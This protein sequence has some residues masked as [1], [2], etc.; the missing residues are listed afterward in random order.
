[1][2][3]VDYYPSDVPH[4][5][6][7]W[8]VGSVD[9]F[10]LYF[11]FAISLIFFFY[12]FYKHVRAWFL[13]KRASVKPVLFSF[14]K[15]AILQVKL[16]K[17]KPSMGLSHIAIFWGMVILT[18]TTILVGIE[19]DLGIRFIH[20]NFYLVLSFVAELGG[21]FL[22]LGILYAMYRRISI[23]PR[24]LR[25]ITEDKALLILLLVLAVQGFIIEALR[26]AYFRY[27]WEHV[28]FVGNFLAGTLFSNLDEESLKFWHRLLWNIHAWTTMVFIG[29]I[30]YSKLMHIFTSPLNVLI[31][32]RREHT[33]Q[34][35]VH[36]NLMELM[37]REDVSE[38]EML[39]GYYKLED[40]PWNRILMTDACTVCGR[41][42][43]VCPAYLTF[44]PL[45]PKEV[46]L[47]IRDHALEVAEGG[48]SKP[49]HLVVDENAIWACTSCGA[50]VHECP[51][52]ID[53]LE[54]IVNVRRGFIENGLQPSELNNAYRGMENQFNPWNAPHDTRD[55]WRKELGVPHVSE[56]DDVEYLL[57]FGCAGN[58]D[59]RSKKTIASL[60]EI[61]RKAGVK[62]A[63]L[64]SDERCTGDSARRTGNE[65]LFQMLAYE[66][67]QTLNS[68]GI[69]KIITICPHCYNTLKN[70]YKAFGGN[71]EV[72]HHTQVIQKLLEEGR[73]KL[74]KRATK[75]IFHD[76]CYLGRHNGVF[77]A[78]RFVLDNLGERI[79]AERSRERS[80]CCGAG[81]GRMWM[82]ER[83]GKR[84]NIERTKE[85]LSKQPDS[86]AVGCP[87]CFTMI[88]DGVNAQGKGDSVKVMDIAILVAQNMES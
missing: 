63:S 38:E 34:H 20:G 15:D 77:D 6:F 1:M 9:F 58:Y 30:P 2:H 80:F 75:V 76:P 53:Q 60:V 17:G 68:Y 56:T 11:T 23:L 3:G 25:N 64:G 7:G 70:E 44:K 87:F 33:A 86:I 4:R 12:G 37:E 39:T 72:Y 82:E 21:L 18:I 26:I 46:V 41:C 28:S 10:L 88:A 62:F 61:L 47:S 73:I 40:I 55:E 24:W 57:W 52:H 43:E 31:N 36:V 29:Y 67:V 71:Y 19:M 45:D 54:L 42:T 69:R 32:R 35:D 65:L 79:E 16:L 78:P 85:L 48:E 8:N 84:I 27:D 13:G 50:C 22:I 83:I 5:V 51:V 74:N 59:P 14:L 49:L 81:G 66:N